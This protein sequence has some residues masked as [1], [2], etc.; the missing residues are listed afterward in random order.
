MLG[1][2]GTVSWGCGQDKQIE[3]TSGTDNV[4]MPRAWIVWAFGIT[5][6][7]RRYGLKIEN[8]HP[9]FT[10]LGE[11]TETRLLTRW[12]LTHWSDHVR[13]PGDPIVCTDELG[14]IWET[15]PWEWKGRFQPWSWTFVLIQLCFVWG[16]CLFSNNTT[17]RTL[18]KSPGCTDRRSASFYSISQGKKRKKEKRKRRKEKK[19][20]KAPPV[21]FPSA[22]WVCTIKSQ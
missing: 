1:T 20:P 13:L 17:Q 4:D 8:S 6:D 2:R 18:R 21:S 15:R 7:H 5:F 14:F 19:P 11:V 12:P 10:E 16:F 22:T 3:V 9:S